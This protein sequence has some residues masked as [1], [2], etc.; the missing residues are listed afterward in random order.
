MELI[1]GL[2]TDALFGPVLLFGR[3]GTAVEVVADKALALAPVNLMLARDL[4][5]RTQVYRELK[6]YRGRPPADLD[7]IALTL[8]KLSQLACDLDEVAELDINPLLANEAGVIGVDARIR[9]APLSKDAKRGSRLAIRP[10]PKELESEENAPFLG[11][12]IIR[13]IRPEDATALARFAGR[14]SP[15]DVRMRFFSAWRSLPPE[16]MARLTQIDYDRAMAFVMIEKKSGEFAGVARFFADPDNTTAEFAVII[17]TDLKGHGLG[18]ILTERLIAYARARGIGDLHGQVLRENKPM[19]AFCKE[20]G[21]S[22]DPDEKSPELV[23]ARLA[24]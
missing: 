24:L 9:V 18:R 10:Y 15:E 7:A 11:P 16:Q 12:T 3:G 6:G 14:L 17:R 20:L 23:R 5:S 21:F 13:P 19:L 22:L 1:V 8:V 4:I 2:T